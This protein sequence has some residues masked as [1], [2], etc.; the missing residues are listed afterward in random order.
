MGATSAVA[1]MGRS[2]AEGSPCLP[3]ETNA[4][5]LFSTR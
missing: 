5:S 1:P 3:L 4:I 2:Y